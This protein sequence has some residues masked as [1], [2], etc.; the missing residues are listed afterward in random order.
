MTVDNNE[1]H[2]ASASAAQSPLAPP[3]QAAAAPVEPAAK[4]EPVILAPARPR[5]HCANCG[6]ALAGRYCHQCG[7]PSTVKRMG[8]RQA[9]G[10]L[11]YVNLKFD[12]KLLHTLK[13]LIAAPGKLSLDHR[14]GIT[15]PYVAPLRL[16]LIV[17]FVVTLI[18]A[19][20]DIRVFQTQYEFE[21]GARITRTASGELVTYGVKDVVIENRRL[22]PKP[23]P[24]AD[25]V[26]ALEQELA[27][28]NSWIDAKTLRVWKAQMNNDIAAAPVMKAMPLFFILI[29]PLLALLIGLIYRDRSLVFSDHLVFTLHVLAFQLLLA[30]LAAA[31]SAFWPKGGENYYLDTIAGVAY[32]VLAC[33]AYYGSSWPVSIAKGIVVTACFM[34][35]IILFGMISVGLLILFTV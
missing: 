5:T 14:H 25:F 13:V 8:F 12:H 19:V 27:K 9:I 16:L 3:P 18:Y 2:A 31:I 1:Q 32:I 20:A 21:P 7:Q 22:L 17:G 11:I 4:A 10:D 29:A 6:A 35:L 23:N 30:L 26:Q 15:V 34:G 28:P 24:P 33:R